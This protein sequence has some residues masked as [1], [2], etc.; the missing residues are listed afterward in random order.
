M[1]CYVCVSYALLNLLLPMTSD[2]VEST[3]SES[4]G[5][6]SESWKYA[7]ESSPQTF[8][9]TTD[10]FIQEVHLLLVQVWVESECS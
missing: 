2:V 4:T 3:K 10:E 8:L 1:L 9:L 7:L 5:S 6:E